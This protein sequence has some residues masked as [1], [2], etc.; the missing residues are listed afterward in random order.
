MGEAADDRRARWRGVG[1]MS[2]HVA[3]SVVPAQ[4]GT[5]IPELVVMGPCF[6]GDDNDQVLDAQ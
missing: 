4:A 6:R 2:L 5:H 1:T 3:R